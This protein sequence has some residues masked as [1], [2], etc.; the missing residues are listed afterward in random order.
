MSKRINKRVIVLGD[1]HCGHEG[2]LTPPGWWIRDERSPLLKALQKETWAEYR[3]LVRKYKDF[4]GETIVVC[5]GDAIDGDKH[6][7]EH[8]TSDRNDQVLMAQKCIQIWDAD[9]YRFIQGT[10]FHTGKAECFEVQLASKFDTVVCPKSYFDV[11]GR[12]MAFR[13]KIGR[14]SI[15]Y[16]RHTSA[17][18]EAM[19]NE[20]D[21]ARGDAPRATIFCFNHVHYH[22]FEGTNDWLAMTLPAL[23]TV[24]GYGAREC[25]GKV[26][27]GITVFDVAPDGSYSWSTDIK[28]IQGAIPQ[29]EVL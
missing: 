29:A 26:D 18:R 17:A 3:A 6:V 5:N 2:G 20:L 28:V 19:M 14:S 10:P 22:T 8:T 27:W 9:T 12:V 7:D 4:D 25:T 13:H 24:S 1:L 15:P 23:Q 11:N 16:L 21:A